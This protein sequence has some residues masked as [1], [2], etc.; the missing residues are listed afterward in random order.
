MDIAE[1]PVQP[2]TDDDEAL[3][4][5]KKLS[6]KQLEILLDNCPVPKLAQDDLPWPALVHCEQKRTVLVP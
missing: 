3:P 4:R 5:K 1:W 2:A 6:F